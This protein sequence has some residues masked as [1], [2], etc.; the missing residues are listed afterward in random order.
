MHFTI[1]SCRWVFLL[2]TAFSTRLPPQ[3]SISPALGLKSSRLR[4]GS[5]WSC[6]NACR[7][8]LCHQ[9]FAQLD[10]A[11]VRFDSTSASDGNFTYRTY[12]QGSGVRDGCLEFSIPF[13]LD[14]MY[15][16]YCCRKLCGFETFRCISCFSTTTQGALR[17]IYGSFSF[18]DLPWWSWGVYRA[19]GTKVESHLLHWQCCDWT[20]CYDCGCQTLV[21]SNLGTR[22]GG[23]GARSSGKKHGK[24]K[25]KRENWKQGGRMITPNIWSKYD[26]YNLYA[27]FVAQKNFIYI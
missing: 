15:C 26:C 9:Q 17:K 12:P 3:S 10:E 6:F 27:H 8:S 1:T 13:I 19:L 7:G 21:P 2:A 23:G 18:Y 11:W 5:L 20:C 22:W 14:P 4:S 16:C 24:K 25:R